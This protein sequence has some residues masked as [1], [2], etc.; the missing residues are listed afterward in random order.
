MTLMW[1]GRGHVKYL[2][3]NVAQGLDVTMAIVYCSP[4]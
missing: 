2:T 4:H 3:Y 1:R